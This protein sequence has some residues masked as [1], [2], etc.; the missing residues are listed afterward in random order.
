[1][2]QTGSKAA[3]CQQPLKVSCALASFALR[4]SILGNIVPSSL[5]LLILFR[6]LTSR[7]IPFDRRISLPATFTSPASRLLPRRNISVTTSIG[8]VGSDSVQST[9]P[10][11]P[12]T[13]N[14]EDYV[15]RCL[16]VYLGEMLKV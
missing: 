6:H 11:G 1:M 8:S 7:M 2:R 5:P 14:M 9:T 12:A 4:R 15:G 16:P 3:P 10:E 13:T